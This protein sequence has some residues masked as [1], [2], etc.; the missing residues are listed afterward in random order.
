MTARAC[1]GGRDDPSI[2]GERFGSPILKVL[3]REGGNGWEWGS[4]GGKG[5]E[6]AMVEEDRIILFLQG[7]LNVYINEV[8]L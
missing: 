3:N 6:A 2:R 7:K 5:R 8:T 4:G 1:N